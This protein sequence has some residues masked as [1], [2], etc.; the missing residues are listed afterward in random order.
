MLETFLR[1]VPALMYSSRPIAA[2]SLPAAIS[3]STSRSRSLSTTGAGSAA[4]AASESR[5]RAS[6]PPVTRREIQA[7]PAAPAGC[8]GGDHGPAA[9]VRPAAGEDLLERRV[10]EQVTAGPGAHRVN[11]VAIVG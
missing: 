3:C 7:P 2:L 4:G 11:D 1:T 8:A 9:R 6:S 5:T 10:L